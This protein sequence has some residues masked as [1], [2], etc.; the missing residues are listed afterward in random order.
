MHSLILFNPQIG[1]FSS[2]TTLGQSEPGSNVNKG[3]LR[4]P[5]SSSITGTSSSDCLVS[6]QDTLCWGLTPLQRSSQ[7]I[8]QPQPT[9]QKYGNI[10]NKPELICLHKVKWFQV[11]QSNTNSFIFTQLNGFKYSYLIQMI[12]FNITHLFVHS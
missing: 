8:L 1:P 4:I 7:C 6:Y 5:Q 11:L 2:A 12:L 3:V 9:G 10:L